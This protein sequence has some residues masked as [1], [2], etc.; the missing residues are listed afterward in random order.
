MI[1]L[2]EQA[3]TAV[4]AAMSRAGKLDAGLRV[5]VEAG[6]CAGYKYLIGLDAE[7]RVDD[8]VVEAGGVK[9]FID[10]DS[11]P[12]LSGMTI[13]FVESLEGSGFTFDNPNAGTKCG[14]GKSFG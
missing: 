1:I 6:G 7:P 2:T 12:L 5:M 4:K 14:C 13:D 8:A 9:V 11:Q 10:P 3:G